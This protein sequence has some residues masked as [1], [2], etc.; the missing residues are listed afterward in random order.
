MDQIEAGL[1][2]GYKALALEGIRLIKHG[3]SQDNAVL[4]QQ[5]QEAASTFQSE[6]ERIAVPTKRIITALKQLYEL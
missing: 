6:L 2:E 1:H 5:W 4:L 3:G